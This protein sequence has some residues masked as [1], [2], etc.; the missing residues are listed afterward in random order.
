MGIYPCNKFRY[1]TCEISVCSRRNYF[2]ITISVVVCPLWCYGEYACDCNLNT[3]PR[4]VI[5]DFGT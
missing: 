4:N 1:L 5:D 3:I 2:Y